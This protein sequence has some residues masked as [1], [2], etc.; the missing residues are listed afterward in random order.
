V[1]AKLDFTERGHRRTVAR[2]RPWLWLAW[3][4]RNC[5]LVSGRLAIGVM[6]RGGRT[7]SDGF[8]AMRKGIG[9]TSAYIRLQKKKIER[10]RAFA[11]HDGLLHGIY[12]WASKHISIGLG[13]LISYGN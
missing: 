13:L 1:T 11:S 8:E 6:A 4:H 12:F 3:R 2:E 7:R 9:P 10:V 5:A